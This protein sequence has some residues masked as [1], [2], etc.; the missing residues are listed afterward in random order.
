MEKKSKK[1]ERDKSFARVKS[2]DDM[3]K[4]G[5]GESRN[6]TGADFRSRWLHTICSSETQQVVVGGQQRLEGKAK[7]NG[8]GHISQYSATRAERWATTDNDNDVGGRRELDTKEAKINEKS[9]RRRL[10]PF[11]ATR[12]VPAWSYHSWQSRLS[13]CYS[14]LVF[15][16][17]SAPVRTQLVDRTADWFETSKDGRAGGQLGLI[18]YSWG[19][20]R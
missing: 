12:V 16:L 20:C 15:G 17:G 3:D 10:R 1:K 4:R 13:R 14:V 19:T 11:D 5:R 18:D 8:H 9:S 2:W 7:I 6:C